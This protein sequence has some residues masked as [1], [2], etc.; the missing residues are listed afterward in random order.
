MSALSVVQRGWRKAFASVYWPWHAAPGPFFWASV[1]AGVLCIERADAAPILCL[2]AHSPF[3]TCLL[4]VLFLKEK[5]ARLVFGL[6]SFWGVLVCAQ[7]DGGYFMAGA[8]P[9]DQLRRFFT[10]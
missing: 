7:A 8:F 1:A 4:S 9:G 3:F 10:V 5:I 2:I 6:L